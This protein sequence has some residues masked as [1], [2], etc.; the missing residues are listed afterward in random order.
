M[1]PVT[2]FW[3]LLF[4]GRSYCQAATQD[5]F[6]KGR[7]LLDKA[8]EPERSGSAH[9]ARRVVKKT[10]QDTGFASSCGIAGS[11]SQ[12]CKII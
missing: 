6:L 3:K 4:N 9:L 2:Y 11:S 10:Q 12:L 1:A 5:R 8:G 7:N